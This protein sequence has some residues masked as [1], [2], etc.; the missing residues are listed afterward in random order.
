MVLA[1]ILGV[2]LR[3]R[4]YLEERSLWLDPAMLALNVVDRGYGELLGRLDMNQAAPPGFLWLSKAIGSAFGY[5]EYSLY[6]APLV[7]GVGAFL[8]F[9]QLSREVLGPRHAPLAFLPMATCS[10]AIYYCGEFRPQSFDLFFTVLVLLSCQSVL[11]RNW[12]PSAIASLTVVGIVGV[13]FSYAVLFVIAGSGSAL[14]LL[15]I[16]SAQPRAAR[17]MTVSFAIVM[18]HFL[19][20]YLLHIRPSIGPDLYSANKAAYAPVV[21]VTKGQ[22]WWWILAVKGYFEFPLG[23]LGIFV[24]PLVGLVT[25]VAVCLSSRRHLRLVAVFGAPMVALIVASSLGRYPMSTGVT[26]V[27]A[28][29]VLFTVPIALVFI[30]FG[31]IRL[32]E[33]LGSK[34]LFSYLVVG[35]LLLPSFYGAF[36]GPRF[37]PQEMRPLVH[38]LDQHIRPGDSV[39]VFFASVP[40][41]RFYTRHDPIDAVL[42]RRPRHGTRDLEL[43]LERVR[44]A[45]RLWVVVSHAFNDERRLIRRTLRPFAQRKTTHRFPGAVLFEYRLRQ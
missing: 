8:L 35:A 17:W 28:R 39:Y 10:T 18:V 23:F 40:A 5:T 41:F 42:G 31:I 20:F 22:L 26:E 4:M 34:K 14:V 44:N 43:D 38:Y 29:F 3:F 13:W 15:A 12:A 9:I 21:A 30:A 16:T 2:A 24:V 36:T 6:L 11:K 27:K 32:C 37:R 19:L 1:T 45:D 7:F 33:V 25:G